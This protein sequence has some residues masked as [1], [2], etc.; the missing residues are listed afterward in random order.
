MRHGL[1]RYTNQKPAFVQRD[2]VMMLTDMEPTGSQS[3]L[4]EV[5]NTHVN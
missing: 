3:R 2:D 5:P 4:G 1:R